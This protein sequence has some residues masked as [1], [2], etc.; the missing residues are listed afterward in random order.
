MVKFQQFPCGSKSKRIRH[1]V[2]EII[3]AFG[4]RLEDRPP[5]MSEEE[6]ER[7]LREVEERQKARKEKKVEA[8]RQMAVDRISLRLH[9][10]RL[11][12]QQ[13]IGGAESSA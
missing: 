2:T 8:K 6:K 10:R 9:N 1:A 4:P 13:K 7:R 3:A 12:E 11:A 5:V